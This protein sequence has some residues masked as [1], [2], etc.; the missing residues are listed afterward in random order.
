MLVLLVDIVMA[1]YDVFHGD[2]DVYYGRSIIV[3]GSDYKYPNN[4]R[5]H[6]HFLNEMGAFYV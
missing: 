4:V 6:S 3:K 1:L 2:P 5:N